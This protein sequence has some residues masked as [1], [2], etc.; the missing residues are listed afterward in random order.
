MITEANDDRHKK[1]REFDIAE[2]PTVHLFIADDSDDDDSDDDDDD[3]ETDIEDETCDDEYLGLVLDES[4][5]QYLLI[6][7]WDM[8][9]DWKKFEY[10]TMDRAP[11]KLVNQL[12]DFVFCAKQILPKS[13]DKWYFLL[14][15]IFQ[16]TQLNV[17]KI[18]LQWITIALFNRMKEDEENDDN[19]KDEKY[20]HRVI[21]RYIVHNKQIP[22]ALDKWKEI[23]E[24]EI[25][26][27]M[28]I[29]DEEMIYRLSKWAANLVQSRWNIQKEL[30]NIIS[31]YSINT[32]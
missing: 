3:D 13:L 14:R 30:S 17:D 9:V 4:T 5:L 21:K 26:C 27:S 10:E 7:P 24:K 11:T 16:T 22:F 6:K 18:K 15:K 31:S 12:Y 25:D 28:V 29:N 8:Y 1:T 19:M 2:T 32:Y 23:M 20:F